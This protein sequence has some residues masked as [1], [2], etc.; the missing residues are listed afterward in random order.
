V[1]APSVSCAIDRV[2]I[3]LRTPA[4]PAALIVTAVVVLTIPL[5]AA[6]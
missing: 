4:A 6:A 3:K 1:A 5:A 2:W